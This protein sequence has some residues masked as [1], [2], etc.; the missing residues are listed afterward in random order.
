MEGKITH[1]YVKL[2]Q[3]TFKNILELELNEVKMTLNRVKIKVPTTVT[4]PLTDKFKVR[5]IL[6]WDSL[7]FHI[8]LKQGMP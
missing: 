4:V 6:K 7:L 5:R 8:M 3:N 2:R 1:E